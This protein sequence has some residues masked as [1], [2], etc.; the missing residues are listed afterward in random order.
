MA[1]LEEAGEEIDPEDEEELSMRMAFYEDLCERQPI[2]ISDV[3]LRQN[4][5]NVQEWQKRIALFKDNNEMVSSSRFVA[6]HL[7]NALFVDCTG[8]YARLANHRP[9]KGIWK[10]S[11]V[12]DWFRA[13][14]GKLRKS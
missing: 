14:L 12:V 9:K 10:A 7:L 4:P 2:L 3:C 13:F 11:L 1:E 6:C 8:I 5:H